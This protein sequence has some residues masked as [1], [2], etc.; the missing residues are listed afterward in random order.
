MLT[1]VS[2]FLCLFVF[3]VLGVF[4][5]N[6]VVR[7]AW[8]CRAV[9]FPTLL[10]GGALL[11][12]IG[13][14]LPYGASESQPQRVV[15]VT[16]QNDAQLSPV[17]PPA[18]TPISLTSVPETPQP[19]TQ[20]SQQQEVIV[21]S[22]D[23]LEKQLTPEGAE[24]LRRLHESLPPELRDSYALIPLSR[25]GDLRTHDVVP[26]VVAQHF[27]ASGAI[28][29]KTAVVRLV[30]T[31]AAQK[32]QS[33]VAAIEKGADEGTTAASAVTT[34]DSELLVGAP[35][36][37]ET[38]T[39]SS[40]NFEPPVP[41]LGQVLVKS[42]FE[43]NSVSQVDALRPAVEGA[44]KEETKKWL[45]SEGLWSDGDA[46]QLVDFKI[47]D[48]FIEESIQQTK[49]QY[50]PIG[51]NVEGEI[52]LQKTHATIQFPNWV[53]EKTTSE[54]RT[55]LQENRTK[56]LGI[57]MG[58]AWLAALL[59]GFTIRITRGSSLLKKFL[60]LPV[61]GLA[62]L[63][64]V[65]LFIGMSVGMAQDKAVNISFDGRRIVCQL[66]LPTEAPN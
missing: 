7:V 31:F 48:A 51:S 57:A 8:N 3:G 63:P 16:D 21:L 45:K 22:E 12:G 62:I 55:A 47:S 53:R 13:L 30:Q 14:L 4:A 39:E 66:D 49:M 18:Q 19:P 59:L 1:I 23:T 65:G 38:I 54:V 56:M 34:E 32:E 29:L 43:R 42:Q 15:K 17:D 33:G 64:A 41:H 20:P 36:N 37:S 9:V 44:L 52:P 11:A 61:M 40:R 27:N 58:G 50:Q 5:L 24:A 28:A 26:V 6:F 35:V 25:P 10:F 60:V 2:G 46:M